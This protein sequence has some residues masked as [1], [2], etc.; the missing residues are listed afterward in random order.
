MKKAD[1]PTYRIAGRVVDNKSSRGITG[2]RV[3]AWDKDLELDDLCG[4][5]V[6]DEQGAFHIAFDESYFKE[7]FFDRR[8]DLFFKVYRDGGLLVSTQDSVLWNVECGDTEVTIQIEADGTVEHPAARFSVEGHLFFDNGMPAAALALRLYEVNFGGLSTRL[9]ETKT[10][11]RGGYLLP[12]SHQGPGLPNIQLRVPDSL[13]TEVT[14][15]A[16]KFNAGASEIMNLVVPT[17]VRPPASEFERLSSDMWKAIG[18]VEKLGQ[19]EEGTA[20]QDLTLLNQTTN[21]DARIMALAALAAKQAAQ[22]GLRQDVLYALFRV[23]LPTDPAILATVPDE[24]VEKALT[25]ANQAG[26]VSLSPQEISSATATFKEFAG[27]AR[28]AITTPGAVSS[29]NDLLGESVPASF[30]DLYFKDPSAADF[31]AQ[32]ADL[33]IPAETLDSLKLQGKFLYLTYNNGPLTRKLQQE[34]GSLARISDLAEKDYDLSHTW[35]NLLTTLGGSGGSYTTEDLVPTIYGGKSA[36]DRLAA[37]AGDLARKV[38]LSFPTQVAARMIERK[39]LPLSEGTA[40]N[41]ASFLRAAAPL[42][43]DLGRTPLNAFLNSA[44]GDLPEMDRA[45]TESLKTLHRLYQVTPS[46][47]SLQAALRLGF[48]SA[49]DIASYTKDEFTRRFAHEFPSGEASLVYGQA[50][51]VHSVTINLFA[52]AKQLDTA[53]P[54][55]ALSPSDDAR[56]SAKNA[57]VQQFPSMAS[58]FGNVDFCQC[59][60]CRSVLSPAAYFVDL[61]EFLNGSPANAQGY[62]P[63]DV[64]I[65]KDSTVPGRR[66]DLGALPLTCENTNTA[67][68]YIDLANEILEYYIAHARLDSNYAYDTGPTTT[69]DLT[70]EPQHIIPQVYNT[71]LKQ[72][73]FPRALPFDLWIETVR[74]FLNYFNSPL[75]QV[76][77]VLR[78]VDNLELFTDAGSHVYYRAQILAEALGLSPSEYD[79]LTVT[80]STSRQPSVRSWYKLYG[81]ADETTALNGQADPDD[82]SRYLIPPLKSAKNLSQLLGLSYQELAD[83]VDTGFLNPSLYPLLFQF[84]RFGI[85][86][87]DAFSYTG[88]PG[89]PPLTTKQQTDFEAVLDGITAR[90]K[91]LNSSSTFN[92][93]TWLTATLTSNYSRQVLVLADNG[94]GCNFE[95]TTLQYADKTSAATPLDFLKLN[96]FVRLW[97]NLGW[98]LEE[99]DRALQ[100]FFLATLPAWTDTNFAA[101]FSSAWKTAL[102]YLAHLDQL[103]TALA[104]SAGRVALLPFWSNLATQGEDSLYAQLFLM[105]GVLNNDWAFDDPRGQFPLPASDF[106]QPRQS[107]F[108]AH[109]A[110]VQGALGLTADE[111]TAIFQ[112]AGAVITTV[113]FVE[114]GQNVTAPDFSL[115]NL[116]TCY[117]YS[118]LAKCLQMSVADLI[119]LRAMSGL[120]PFHGL[121]GAALSSLA[122]DILFNQTLLFVKQVAAVQNSGF[123]V[124]DLRYLLRHEFDPVGKYKDDP[125][126]LMALAQSVANGVRQ[127][128]SQGAVPPALNSMAE[129]LLDQTLSGLFPDA[130]LKA[131]FTMLTNSQTFTA[132]KSGVATAIDPKPFAAEPRLSFSYDATEQLQSVS[133]QGPLPDWKKEELKKINTTTTFSDLLDAVQ[134]LA[135]EALNQRV[136]D[137]LGVWASLAQ[138]EAVRAPVSAAIPPGPLVQTDSALSLSYDQADRLQWLGYRGVLTD[139][140]RNAL[141]GVNSSADLQHLLDDIQGQAIVAYSQLV[142]SILAMWVNVQTFSATQTAANQIDAD[143]FFAALN[144]AQQ[145]G[146]IAGPIPQIQFDYDTASTTQ[147]LSCQGVLTDLMRGQLAALIPTSTLLAD[148][149]QTVHDRGA[150]LFQ[151]LAADLITA[152]PADLDKYVAPFL[153]LDSS[154]QKKQVKAELVKV[155]LPLQYQKLSRQFVV[156]ILSANLASDPSLTGALLTDSALLSDPCNPGK[157]LLG[158]FLTLA[159]Q[160][161]SASYYASPDGTSNPQDSGVATT[162]D[163]ADA[164]NQKGGAASAH[165]E[166]YLQVPT[167]GPYRF[168]A[169]LGDKD[170]AALFRLDAPASA[171]LFGNPIIP[172]TPAAKDHD[173]V[174]QF[175]QLKGGVL[176]HFTLDFFNLGSHGASLL[177]Q[178]ENLPKGPLSQVIL[179]PEEAVNAFAR[180]RLLLSKALQILQVTGL[181]ERE[182]SYLIANSSQ[183]SNLRLSSLPT[184]LGDISSANVTALFSQ[185]LTLADYA[186]LRKGPGG[187]TDGLIN[188]FENVGQTFTE[189]A[190][191]QDTNKD[192]A[193]PWTRLANLTRRDAS[194]VRAVAESFGLLQSQVVGAARRVTATDDFGNNRGIRRIWEALQLVQIVGIP[195]VPLIASTGIASAAPPAG[196][197][198]PDLIAENFKNAVKAQYDADAWR[199]IAQSVFDQLRKKKRD[200]LVAH[201]LSPASGLGLESMEELFE[202]FLVDAGMEPVVQTSRLRLAMSSVQTFVQRCLLNLENGNSQPA[203]NVAPNAIDAEWWAW[204]KRYRV[205]QANREIFL[206]PENWMVPELRLDK[207]DLFQALESALLQGDVTSD[208][209][210][211]A[212]F[213]YL[214]GLEVRSRLDI[215]ATYLD[216]NLNDAGLSTLYVLGRTYGHPHKYFFRTYSG[217]T[218]SGWEPVTVDIEGDHIVL[219]VWK[220]RLNIF[221]VNFI[222][223][224]QSP[225]QP[226]TDTTPVASLTFNRFATLVSD[227]SPDQQV[228]VQLHWSQ[229]SQGKWSN[230]LSTDVN[231]YQPINVTMGFDARKDVFIHVSKEVNPGGSDGAVRVHLDFHNERHLSFRVTSKNCA[232]DFDSKYWEPAAPM[233]YNVSVIEAT[234]YTGSKNLQANFQT[235]ISDGG[236]G[237]PFSEPILKTVNNF[238]ILPCGNPVSPSPFLD[239]GA[240]LYKEAGSLVSPFFYKDLSNP[241]IDVLPDFQDELTFFVQPTL[242]EEPIAAWSGWA[243]TPPLATKNWDDPALIDGI[244]VIAQGPTINPVGPGDPL[245]SI[246]QTQDTA[247][248]LTNPGTAISY[249]N[250]WIGRGGAINIGN[251]SGLDVSGRGLIAGLGMTASPTFSAA[252]AGLTL[253]G[254]EGLDVNRMADGRALRSTLPAANLDTLSSDQTP[255]G[256]K[257]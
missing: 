53:P 85:D 156:Q 69:A 111:I 189:A 46:S 116:S 254:K 62:T 237:T 21:W 101:A 251:L 105:P 164:T 91:G 226:P 191:S 197:P 42:G 64:L 32:A 17:K 203:L 179:Y 23:G 242:S 149:L 129:G 109:Q 112:D 74:G 225:S 118:A 166:G 238:G 228:R 122:D 174:S 9:A 151:S 76:L 162:A 29:F 204:M 227:M 133:F 37:Y 117:R 187:S 49:R 246:Y 56:Q 145:D 89:Y 10:D 127:I 239:P 77:D 158:A 196:S 192:P 87:S 252:T 120:N 1:E 186:D 205:W 160:G 139:A 175:A 124:E 209:V 93:R 148:L 253:V 248:W 19:A 14:I 182:I 34:V 90:Y 11:A 198:T 33:G 146:S 31:W 15:S 199:P 121:S 200:A 144:A 256:R 40:P 217:G 79:V 12:Y 70:A 140:R 167:D 207:T 155:F 255:N 82:A 180:A 172:S 132:S 201:L 123:T 114:N 230:R 247:D 92:A 48:T 81:Y 185:F 104:P 54:V 234:L 39:D 44:G 165:F 193:T 5:A 13:G 28:L 16:T 83:V 125:N 150:E 25:K 169:E 99:T 66:P 236:T 128:Q 35:Q 24:A 102:V 194:V 249:D 244:N 27:G 161:V 63:L 233:V 52:M 61:L 107:T 142:G 206:F 176:Y 188:I 143:A 190:S 115:V 241:N 210:E 4:S 138:Y 103:N 219:A 231:L 222:A 211:D 170:S 20:R 181:G 137:V 43:Y 235:N 213:A 212:F 68:P 113:T 8:P 41:V 60:D 131:L 100:L 65:G 47:E 240:P 157:S 218:W 84:R 94:S 221:W 96:L 67:M 168:F 30:A 59:E 245:Y 171:A 229:Y 88:Q 195:V 126:A 95:E 224:P 215:V 50:Q 135:R 184:R 71:I 110:A 119:A 55:Y 26:I 2:L 57:V 51:T 178:G 173:E 108:S 220:G 177:I 130:I 97:K 45:S 72:D 202:Y 75:A 36:A 208:L 243:V 136:G 214:S 78:P 152:V 73:V 153:G 7:G 154:K 134:A 38:R 98:T 22:T 18:G 86:M 159:L 163:T 3:E 216:Q 257:P 6:T 147:T 183:F 80:D 223:Q 58:L 250:T 232:P 141:L 106:K